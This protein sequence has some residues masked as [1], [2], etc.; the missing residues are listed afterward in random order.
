MYKFITVI[1]VIC[2]LIS[3]CSTSPKTTVVQMGDE[4]LSKQ[5]II[6]EL[7]KLDNVEK[8][9]ESNKGFNGTNVASVLFFLPG[10]V[11]TY[12]DAHEAHKQIQSRRAH[13]NEIYNRKY[14]LKDA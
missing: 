10:I 1:L 3:G 7:E 8:K 6:S 14:M 11:Y 12:V 9:I 4:S 2:S 5:Q 13:L